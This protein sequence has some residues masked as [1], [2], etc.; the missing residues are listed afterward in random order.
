MIVRKEEGTT[1][2]TKRVWT[3]TDRADLFRDMFGLSNGKDYYDKLTIR[4]TNSDSYAGAITFDVTRGACE[5]LRMEFNITTSDAASCRCGRLVVNDRA[6][7][8]VHKQNYG[9]SEY[10]NIHKRVID[11]AFWFFANLN[12]GAVM[13]DTI[14]Y[15]KV[16]LKYAPKTGMKVGEG[17][18][19]FADVNL[20]VG[21]LKKMQVKEAHKI[22]NEIMEEW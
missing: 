14:I 6:L 2:E 1:Q 22:V 11:G 4:L 16:L 17:T 8:E 13:P 5:K 19:D 10:G 7:K 15:E 12:S 18:K 9:N 3:S 21:D 20:S